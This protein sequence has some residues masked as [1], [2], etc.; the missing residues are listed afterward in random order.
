WLARLVPNAS[1]P[2]D[3]EAESI[4]AAT[5]TGIEQ[6]LRFGV[7]TVGDISRFCSISRAVLRESP[8]RAVSFGE[9]LAMGQRRELLDE[10]LARAVDRSL[11]T[12][13]LRIG[14]T[15]HAP[16]SIESHGY[17]RCLAI[18]RS[19][20]L[21]LTTHLAETPDET[22][23]LSDHSGPFRE[24]WER[25]GGWDSQVDRFRGGPIRYAAELGLLDYPTLLAHVNYCDDDELAILAH[26]KASVACCP[27]THAYFGHPP[28]RWR[29]M[30]A[31]GINVTVGTDSCASSPDLNLVDDLRLLH[32]IAPDVAPENLWEM[33]TIRA[34]RSLGL[35]N[36]IGSIAPGKSADLVA[37][38]VM[39]HGALREIL[40]N[41]IIPSATW[42]AGRKTGPAAS[43]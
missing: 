4:A 34:A 5:R 33:A 13:L 18:A 16:Y 29:E 22:P 8:L 10:R 2:L 40:Q 30:L 3:R 17:Q 28:H 14:I 20:D 21:P 35:Q 37:F 26:G 42:V 39:S 19:M 31:A 25:I 38:P 12:E 24:L 32:E 41:P 23:F 15:P 7:T 9:V 43:E 11:E 1:V 6:C 27:R 36:Q